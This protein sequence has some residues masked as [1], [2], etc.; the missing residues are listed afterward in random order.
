M[1]RTGNVLN[2]HIATDIFSSSNILIS[3]IILGIVLIYAIRYA[4]DPT[5]NPKAKKLI[6]RT[7]KVILFFA[8]TR[9]V[10]VCIN[11]GTWGSSDSKSL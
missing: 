8:I 7:R 1:L 10:K 11:I 6:Q 4:G 3:L 2:D 5:L 9:I